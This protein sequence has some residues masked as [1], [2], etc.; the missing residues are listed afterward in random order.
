MKFGSYFSGGCLADVGALQAGFEP[1]FS[2]EGDPSNWA[3]SMRIADCAERNLGHFV[4]RQNVTTVRPYLLPYVDWFHASP[5]CKNASVAKLGRGEMEVD[6]LTAMATADY[7]KC[8]LPRFVSIENVW[9]YREFEAW[10]IIYRTLLDCGY[11]VRVEHLNSA[12][13]GVPQTRK[14][15][16]VRAVR[17]GKQLPPL[18]P[19]HAKEPKPMDLFGFSLEKWNGWH[20][21]I[22]DLLDTLEDDWF[23]DWQIPKLPQWFRDSFAMGNGQWSTPIEG[24]VP[25]PAVTANGNQSG[26]KAFLANTD[27]SCAISESDCRAPTVVGS[28]RMKHVKAFLANGTLNSHGSSMTI[29]GEDDPSFTITFSHEKRPLRAFVMDNGNPNANGKTRY[30]LEDGPVRTMTTT[31]ASTRAFIVPGGN[32]SSARSYDEQE[33]SFTIGDTGRAGNIPRSY[34][35]GRVVRLSPRCLARFQTLPDWY[36]LPERTSDAIAL[37][38]NGVPCLLMQRVGESFKEVL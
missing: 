28:H 34:A 27:S 38:G 15:M 32:V 12:D 30:K 7:I 2:V 35:N 9:Q 14:R 6:I 36:M 21:A 13:F 25:H 17:G 5:V 11:G 16:I 8:H 22:A 26:L 20:G 37:I 18:P 4:L 31:S 19:T 3:Q 10:H 23:A 33:P 29:S 24:E 1:V